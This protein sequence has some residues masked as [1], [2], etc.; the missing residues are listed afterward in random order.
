V[1]DEPKDIKT[2]DL[3]RVLLR[4]FLIQASWSFDRMQTLG[5]AYAMLPALRK[6]HPDSN[7]LTARINIHLEYFNT[8]PYFASF[9]LGAVVRLEE[10]RASGRNPD[11][12]VR[13]LKTALMASLGAMGDSFF[14]GALKPF[15]VAVAV[16]VFFAGLWWAPLAF[17][18]IYNIWH[19]GLRA[20]L[21]FLGYESGWDAVALVAE[22]NF[23]KLARNLK[24]LSLSLLGGLLGLLPQWRPEFRPPVPDAGPL[25]IAVGGLAVTLGM[26]VLLRTGG[27]P[28]KLMV[29]LAVV[30][31]IL[32]FLG[33]V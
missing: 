23:T 11:A 16:A 9:I 32:T 1:K 15:A 7:E 10:E 29:V 22:F 24:T 28:A 8:Q 14:W 20:W 21:L 2:S 19:V 31:V 12:D 17:L 33:A 27:T 3:V 30:C 5:F 13:G 26:V 6:L 18:V 4:A 25:T